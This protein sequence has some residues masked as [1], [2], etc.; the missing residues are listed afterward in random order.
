MLSNPKVFS[1]EDIFV[2]KI[3]VMKKIDIMKTRN[4]AVEK[5]PRAED[6]T[7]NQNENPIDT[8]TALNLGDEKSILDRIN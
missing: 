1:T 8:A 6:M 3:W 5:N 2:D 4:N 7:K